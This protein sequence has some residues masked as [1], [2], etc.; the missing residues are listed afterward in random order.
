LIASLSGKVRFIEGNSLIVEIG[1]VGISVQVPSPLRSRL[2][3]GESI[4]LFTHLIVRQDSLTLYGFET[5][6][7][8]DY[9][10]LLLGV[11]GIGPRLALGIISALDPIAIR[12]A[13]FNEQAD[14]FSQVPGVGKRTAQKILLHLQDRV[15]GEDGLKPYAPMKEVD[16]EVLTALTSLGY[17]VVEAQTAIQ[18]IPADAADDI[19]TRLMLALQF[20]GS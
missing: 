11:D 17:S 2:Q 10:I 13:V 4:Y 5:A 1:G 7:T 8:R 19:E 16:S 9:F 14:I 20:F 15:V 12:R 6:E 18:S 3:P